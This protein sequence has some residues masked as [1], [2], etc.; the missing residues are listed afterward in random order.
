MLKNMQEILIFQSTFLLSYCG[1]EKEG[2][3]MVIFKWLYQIL[4]LLETK[5]ILH[6]AAI[7]SWYFFYLE[8][9]TL[10]TLSITG[11]YVFFSLIIYHDIRTLK[12]M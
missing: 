7:D 3:R 9:M 1:A 6:N 4:F 12:E 8:R 11:L 10:S 2:T 5:E